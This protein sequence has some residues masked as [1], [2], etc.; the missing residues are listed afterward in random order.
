MR[1]VL[2][3]RDPIAYGCISA[4]R[5]NARVSRQ[6]RRSKHVC[7]SRRGMPTAL[8]IS[9]AFVF[10]ARL[11]DVTR[12]RRVSRVRTAIR[13]ARLNPSL[14]RIRARRLVNNRY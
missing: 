2:N 3:V 8:Q 13:R 12:T 11:M 7:T 4:G 1:K 9:D 14:L 6:R 10:E 5:G